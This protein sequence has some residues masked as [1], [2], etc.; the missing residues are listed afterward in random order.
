MDCLLKHFQ[1]GPEY[2][3]VSEDGGDA[4]G[5][6]AAAIPTWCRTDVGTAEL[7]AP[8]SVAKLARLPSAFTCFGQQLSMS[9]QPS[10]LAK[11]HLYQHGLNLVQ[12]QAE[13]TPASSL[14]PRTKRRQ[15]TKARIQKAALKQANQ[16]Q[17]Q[18]QQ[19]ALH[20]AVHPAA[21]VDI[22]LLQTDWLWGAPLTLDLGGQRDTAGL[23]QSAPILMDLDPQQSKSAAQ[24]SSGS[25]LTPAKA[26]MQATD[27][28]STSAVPAAVADPA[29]AAGPTLAETPMLPAESLPEP[30]DFPDAAVSPEMCV[31][32][33]FLGFRGIVHPPSDDGGT[34][35]TWFV[36]E[37]RPRK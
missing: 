29:L 20:A 30:P 18:Q 9:V 19:Q 4:S 25:L 31:F 14:L 1:F 37:H 15:K 34:E 36:P 27:S 3:E 32:F 6:I 35:R 17:Q 28:P 7:R 2:S 26:F 13:S 23:G 21:S 16:Q 22:V 8:V 24:V 5:D 33:F 11:A 10:I 12:Q